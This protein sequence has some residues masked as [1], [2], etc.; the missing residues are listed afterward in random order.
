MSDSKRQ[1]I[2]MIGIAL[3]LL[4]GLLLYFS[5][6]QP[7][8]S[9]Q[10]MTEASTVL[11]SV[12]QTTGSS[13]INASYPVNINSCSAEEL[14]TIDG[15]GESRAYAIIEYRNYIGGYTSVDQIKNIKGIGDSFYNSVAPYLC[16]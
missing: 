6:S 1:S 5:L 9:E 15:I 14:M 3:L 8:I 16:V 2:I 4:S 10:D 11:S 13:V 7:R 12:Y